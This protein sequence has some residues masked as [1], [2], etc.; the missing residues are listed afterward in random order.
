MGLLEREG[1]NRVPDLC[2]KATKRRV[3]QGITNSDR[4]CAA[5]LCS[6][7]SQRTEFNGSDIIGGPPF[8]GHVGVGHVGVCERRAERGS[9]GRGVAAESSF[10]LDVGATN[11]TW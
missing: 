7:G 11:L 6:A 9:Y 2:W 5:M 8:I 4:Q 3:E 10:E 1:V